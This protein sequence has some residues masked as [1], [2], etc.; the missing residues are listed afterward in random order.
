MGCYNHS[1]GLFEIQVKLPKKLGTEQNKTE[2]NKTITRTQNTEHCVLCSDYIL[3]RSV[4]YILFRSVFRS[5]FCSIPFSNILF[6]FVLFRS[7]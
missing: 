4:D 5:V 7:S 1:N 2:R 6:R 3:F